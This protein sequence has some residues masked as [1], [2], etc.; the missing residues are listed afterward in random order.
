VEIPKD[1]KKF[2]ITSDNPV[3][4]IG[5]GTE[6]QARYF[7]YPFDT[8]K[9]YSSVDED[10]RIMTYREQE[11]FILPNYA[12]FEKKSF[13]LFLPI[14]PKLGLWLHDNKQLPDQILLPLQDKDVCF[15]WHHTISSADEKIYTSEI[16]DELQTFMGNGVF[17]K[18][19]IEVCPTRESR[20]YDY[21]MKYVC[22]IEGNYTCEDFEREMKNK[23]CWDVA[24]VNITV[25]GSR[26]GIKFCVYSLKGDVST[27][28]IA[29]SKE[30]RPAWEQKLKTLG[31]I[32]LF[33]PVQTNGVGSHGRK[34]VSNKEDFH[35]NLI[36]YCDQILPFSQIAAYTA[37]QLLAR[38][39]YQPE[40][41]RI[42]WPNDV[43]VG[44][45]FY[46]WQNFKKIG[47]CLTAVRKEEARYWVTVGVGINYNLEDF[48]N[49]DQPTISVKS[50]LNSFGRNHKSY[51]E[52]D[53]T[54]DEL[55]QSVQK[56]A[57]LFLNNLAFV[58]KLGLA[59]F[60]D[61]EDPFWQ[62]GSESYWLYLGQR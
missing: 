61:K 31:L 23:K 36:F 28:R 42:R 15:F 59:K 2:F 22:G 7:V 4:F 41:F 37:C 19:T 48:S 62:F 38:E 58:Q 47:G 24:C 10:G 20:A 60:Y 46:G 26:G 56:F 53:F 50:F 44:H 9:K 43:M 25:P 16:T 5:K 52:N 32:V 39:T 33:A 35:V 17:F 3:A 8:G 34:W 12:D 49:I 30:K 54:R 21:F 40:Y 13:D 29:L 18:N 27:H 55:F 11:N 57:E 45:W 51:R 6:L 1:S 14:D